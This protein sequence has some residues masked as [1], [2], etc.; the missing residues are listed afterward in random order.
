MKQALAE[1]EPDKFFT[2]AHY[3]GFPAVLVRLEAA[4]VEELEDLLTEACR[5]QAKR[6]AG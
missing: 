2:E 6:A 4:C 1:A 5:I 3:N